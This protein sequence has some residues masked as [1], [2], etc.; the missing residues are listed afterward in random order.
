MEHVFRFM[1]DVKF[2]YEITR[3]VDCKL[4]FFVER[5]KSGKVRAEWIKAAAA[6]IQTRKPT[7]PERHEW[8][9]LSKR[10]MAADRVSPYFHPSRPSEFMLH[11][12]ASEHFEK[13]VGEMA[14]ELVQARNGRR[15]FPH[16]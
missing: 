12:T 2:N 10:Y 3:P 5:Q 7:P 1:A 6:L 4:S 9:V 15:R 16:H 14:T 8:L 11:K 13:E